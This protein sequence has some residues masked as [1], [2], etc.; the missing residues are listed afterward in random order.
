MGAN[1]LIHAEF[2]DGSVMLFK[3]Y[4]R[5]WT[6]SWIEGDYIAGEE[7]GFA[8]ELLKR[9]LYVINNDGPYIETRSKIKHIHEIP[10]MLPTN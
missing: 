10:D 5:I 1:Y 7:H 3:P 6:A 8:K 4:E 2:E 9:G